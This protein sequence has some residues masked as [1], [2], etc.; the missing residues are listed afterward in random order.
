MTTFET[1]IATVLAIILL[2][3]IIVGLCF[4]RS[5]I[6]HI[7]DNVKLHFRLKKFRERMEAQKEEKQNF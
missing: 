1:I 5:F 3:T 4:T 6:S 7:V 2:T